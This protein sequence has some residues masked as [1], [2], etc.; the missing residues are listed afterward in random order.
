MNSFE[1][2]RKI[3]ITVG[4]ARRIYATICTA[5]FVP[6]MFAEVRDLMIGLDAKFGELNEA[7]NGTPDNGPES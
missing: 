2:D 3:E 1:D 6:S 5:S 7:S 4:D